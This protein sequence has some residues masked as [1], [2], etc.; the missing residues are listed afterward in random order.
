MENYVREFCLFFNSEVYEGTW[1]KAHED[2]I[3]KKDKMS[4]QNRN[5]CLFTSTEFT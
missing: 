3:V 1:T 4:R 5:K 2:K